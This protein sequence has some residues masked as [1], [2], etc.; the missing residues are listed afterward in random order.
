MTFI[1][2]YECGCLT[3]LED[4]MDMYGVYCV[5]HCYDNL[6][7]LELEKLSFWSEAPED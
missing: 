4:D 3:F 5:N 7:P 2:H 6:P 1:T